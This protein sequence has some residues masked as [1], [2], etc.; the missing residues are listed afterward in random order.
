[1]KKYEVKLVGQISNPSKNLVITFLFI[2]CSG[3]ETFRRVGVLQWFKS[4]DSGLLG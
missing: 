3:E 1:M 4:L 2:E